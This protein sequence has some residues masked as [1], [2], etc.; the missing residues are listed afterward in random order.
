MA[1]KIWL[2]QQH[3]V[4][5]H[6]IENNNITLSQNINGKEFL[7]TTPNHLTKPQCEALHI[8]LMLKQLFL[9][10]YI[11]MASDNIF[12]STVNEFEYINN[13]EH[14]EIKISLYHHSHQWVYHY[15]MTINGQIS[16]RHQTYVAS[17]EIFIRITVNQLIWNSQYILQVNTIFSPNY[18]PNP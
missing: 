17:R 10:K 9:V 8:L 1:V 12:T 2:I 7:H 4:G 3:Y 16:F 13:K 11:Q 14:H 15:V 5:V 18:L 6:F